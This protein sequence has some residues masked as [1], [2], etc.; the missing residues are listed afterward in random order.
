MYSGHVGCPGCGAAIAMRFTLKALGDK[1]IVES[2]KSARKYRFMELDYF[3][4]VRLR[5][6]SGWST[7]TICKC[8]WIRR[9]VTMADN[10][11]GLLG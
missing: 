8:N 2:K 11:M 9:I 7:S 3:F 10:C 1:T 6:E 5:N 4:I